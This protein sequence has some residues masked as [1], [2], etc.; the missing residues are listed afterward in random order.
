[1]AV[2]KTFSTIMIAFLLLCTGSTAYA[3]LKLIPKERIDSVANPPLAPNASDLVFDDCVIR[4]ECSAEDKGK[5]VYEYG[6]VNAGDAPLVI[7]RLV[8][9]CSCAVARADDRTVAPGMRGVIRLEYSPEGRMGLNIRRIF[10]YT[11]GQ[12]QPSA[13]L[14]LEVLHR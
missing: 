1:M 13:I 8:S 5:L 4:T 2:V 14:R 12:R 11:D 6:F 3:Q 10:V 9:T 7:S